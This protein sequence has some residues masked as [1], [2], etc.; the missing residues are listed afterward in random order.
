MTAQRVFSIKQRNRRVATLFLLDFITLMVPL[1]NVARDI[2]V[3]VKILRN[4]LVQKV[5]TPT[6]RVPSPAFPVHREHLPVKKKVWNATNVLRV[7]YN[8]NRNNQNV[9][10]SNLAQSWPKEDRPRS[11]CHS[12]LKLMTLLHPGL[13]HARPEQWETN[14]Q[15][16]RAKIAPL[17]HNS[18]IKVRPRAMGA[19]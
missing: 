18:P 8:L 3:W 13:Q 14:L 7:I 16:N 12:G 9:I 19:S 2:I 6:T 15:M 1:K 11:S 10:Q 17:G 5:R 4:D